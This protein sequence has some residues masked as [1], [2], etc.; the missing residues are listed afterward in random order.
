MAYTGSD[1]SVYVNTYKVVGGPIEA[2][3]GVVYVIDGVIA[4]K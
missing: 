3:N 2:D 1:G 4:P